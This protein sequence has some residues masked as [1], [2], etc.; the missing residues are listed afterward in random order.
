MSNPASDTQEGKFPAPVTEP[1]AATLAEGVDARA[2]QLQ[3]DPPMEAYRKCELAIRGLLAPYV[4]GDA[5][6]NSIAAAI[7]TCAQ[8]YAL[9]MARFYL[10]SRAT[11]A[12]SPDPTSG[13]G[14]GRLADR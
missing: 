4:D 9:T 12:D 3:S 11:L 8:D 7:M 1:G 6:L 10:E 5:E 13:A 14:D 2:L